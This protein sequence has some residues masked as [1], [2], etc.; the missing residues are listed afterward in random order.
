MTTVTHRD[1]GP[2]K[3]AAEMSDS[4]EAE[5]ANGAD[6]PA[7]RGGSSRWTHGDPV[8]RRHQHAWVPA[9][10]ALLTLLIGLSDILAIF[11]PDLV[12]RLHKINYL[13][14]GTLTT[15]TRSADVIIGLMLLMLAHGLRR[16]KRRAWQA[17]AALL[18]FDIG[19]HVTNAHRMAT[20]IVAA[21]LL[22]ALLYFREEFYAEGDRRTR[23]RA[24][25]VFGCLIVADVVI[26]CTYIL[27]AQHLV[28]NYSLG[29]RIQE[30]LYGLVGVSGPVQW[31]PEARGDLFAIMA[32]ALGIFTLVVTV[33]LFLRPA[34]PR[35]RLGPADAARVRELLGRHGDRDSLGYFALRD[36]K[37]VIWSPT[38]KACVCYR[39][40]SGVMLASGDPIGDPEAWP[41]AIAPFLDE[42]ARHAWAP[43]VMGCSELG[44]EVWCREGNL[45]A[46]ELGDEAIV[47]VADFSL[48][49]RSM[50][51]VRQMVN[52]VSKN[53][54][55]ADVRRVGDIPP[56][57]IDAIVRAADSWRGSQ[58]ERG[59]SM[60][61]GPD[62]RPRR[63]EL[64]ARHGHRERRG[65]GRAAAGPV[66]R[67]RPV[68]GP[69]APGQGR[70][71]RAERLPHRGGDQG[72]PRP[73]R[74][75]DLAELRGVPRRAGAGRA[76]RRR[77]GAARL[78]VGPDLPVQ[79]VP[80]RVA[81]Q[82]QRQVQ[83]GLAAAVLR[84]PEHQ[85]RAADR[86][87]RPGGGGVPGLAAAR[88][89]PHR[90]QTRP[91]QTQAAAGAAALTRLPGLPRAERTLVM[92]VVN[93]TPDSFSD[94]GRWF[95]ADAAIK[96]GLDLVAQGADL[97]DVGG[98]STRP[99][100]QRVPE[101]EELRRIGPVVTELAG[102]GVPVS[103]DTMRAAVA[104]FALD[105]GAVLVNDVSGGLAD[106]QLPRLVA[107]AGV[108]YVVVHW[109]GHSRDMY[110][111]AV[112]A[113]VVSEVRDELTTR[114]DAVVAAGVD[115]GRIV[116]DPGLGFG[117]RP[118]HNWPLLTHLA[119][120][121]R[122][123]GRTFPVLVGASRKRFLGLLLAGPDGTPRPF[124]GSDAATV[125]ISALAATAGAWCVRVHQVPANADAV[126]VA[127]AW[128][129][130]SAGPA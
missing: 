73:R 16:R 86:G 99:G 44:A 92:G 64:R 57:E 59:F 96:H 69:H 14:P 72:R 34:E 24:L 52:R 115:P 124:D 13:V 29:Q 110:S 30:A 18:A 82:V 118:D 50:R 7:A 37:S 62:R 45:T 95:G 63:R 80:D 22:V 47:N 38:G 46:L 66:G 17:V 116:V 113:D 128:R 15:V 71:A 4:D 84:V 123:G 56:R 19:I 120:L 121:G 21:V 43:A 112:Y 51:N 41:G 83:P 3:R 109:R 20:T 93:V 85:G 42:A 65:P 28:T 60:A 35:A 81:V 25:W 90:A 106:P 111:R 58:T 61:L 129:D 54:Y 91:G 33:Y 32:S 67:R 119:D 127:A 117:K 27:L 104:E 36:D 39:V 130:A 102:A 6:L 103:I 76:D 31:L 8:D 105:A 89:A 74:E 108:S 114:I 49:G 53:G 55:V 11:R 5:H 79:V 70:P 40:V 122:L 125:A 97:V 10:A 100:A 88:A 48:S 87:G 78:A 1:L 107:A 75:A 9:S 23:W 26:G 77:P 12:Y 101:E 2:D 126:R 98:E 94:G 68:P